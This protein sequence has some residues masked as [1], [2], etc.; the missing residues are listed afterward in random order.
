M[1]VALDPKKIITAT[2][3]QHNSNTTAT[4]QQH[5]SNTTANIFAI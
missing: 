3:Q 2:Q 4:Q 5:I 1:I